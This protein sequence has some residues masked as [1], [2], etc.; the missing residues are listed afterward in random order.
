MQSWTLGI[1]SFSFL[2]GLGFHQMS[3]LGKNILTQLSICLGLSCC[4]SL[5]QIMQMV[6]ASSVVQQASTAA[7]DK[8]ST[9]DA[10]SRAC[11]SCRRRRLGGRLEKRDPFRKFGVGARGECTGTTAA[12]WLAGRLGFQ[13]LHEYEAESHR[14]RVRCRDGD[15][16]KPGYPRFCVSGPPRGAV[17]AALQTAQ[18]QVQSRYFAKNVEASKSA[19]LALAEGLACL[20]GIETI[21]TLTEHTLAHSHRV[22]GSARN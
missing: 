3:D 5:P 1:L 2:D 17:S 8:Q 22:L 13:Q 14:A 18:E 9:I 10:G 19:K 11:G 7:H 6:A 4:N 12:N 20:G 21:Y 15:Q 16:W